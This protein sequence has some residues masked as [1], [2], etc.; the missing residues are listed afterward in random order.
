MGSI[1]RDIRYA[2][3]GLR[4]APGFTAAAVLTLALGIGATVAVFSIVYGVLLKP[5]PYAEASRL[6]VVTS[7]QHGEPS[8]MSAL[9]FVDYRSQSHSFA[10]MSAVDYNTAN[11]TRSGAAPLRLVVGQVSA[12][13]FDLLGVPAALGRTFAPDADRTGAPKTIVLG[14]GTWRDR[15]AGDPA[16]IGRT[17][18][19]DGDP[20]TVIGVAPG[21]LRYPRQAEAWVPMQ[22]KAWQMEPSGRGSH[23]FRGVGRLK[24]GVTAAQADQ[25]LRDIAARLVTQYPTTNTGVGA[26]A[27]PLQNQMVQ[28][29]R[30]AL[31]TLLAA[32][33][34]VLLVA[35]ANVANLLL[36]R[37][38]AREGEMA[39]RTALG[40][41]RW[42]LVRQL[43]SE[44][45]LLAG[46]GTGVG[47]LLARWLVD[48]VVAYGPAGLP[49]LNEVGVDGRVLLFA[50]AMAVATAI[51]FGL[52]PAL[53]GARPNVSA[54]LHASGRGSAGRRGTQRTRNVLVVV[55]TALAVV[56]LVGA[57]LFL[58]SFA[59]L[60]GVDP[61]FA[62]GNVS[63][64]TLSL[65]DIKYPNDHQVA[66][67][68]ERLLERLRAAPGVT[69]AALGFGRPLADE[70]STVVFE[71]RGEP[72]STPDTRRPTF[73]RPVSPS[74]FRVLSVPIL[75][76]RAFT[77]ADRTDGPE[78][79]IVSREF[80][81][82]YYRGKSPLG[83]FLSL[84]W[85]RDSA[86]W[87]ANTNVG[88]EIV[89]VVPDITERGPGVEPE[90][91][92]YLPFAQVPI[93]DVFVMVRSTLALPAVVAE[94]RAA[95]Q[96][97]DPDVPVFGQTTLRDALSQSIAQPR[98]YVLLL[99][100]FAGLALLLAALGIY[101]VIS[102]GVSTRI[103]EFGI[104]IALG[105]TR[106]RV[107]QLTIRQGMVLA[108]IG[109]PIGLV[110]AY[111]LTRFVVTLLFNPGAAD[112]VAFA[113]AAA[114]LL[115]AA[116]LASYLPARRAAAI[117]PAITMRA[118]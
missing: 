89:G 40:A 76:G 58:R 103:R 88:G 36:V 113:V 74:Y 87:G 104:R 82:R 30:K 107:I 94:T 8:W 66:A 61:G 19:L 78:V 73:I 81:R 54:S 20:F 75:E 101:G 62:P 1:V 60:V 27:W 85:G 48:A 69:D 84:S 47:A 45:L 34:F 116:A 68:S 4:N 98:F 71:V 42:D 114:A 26:G 112:A 109:I 10:G 25:E 18:T 79:A 83:K 111:W 100:G 21:W 38:T 106:A 16:V 17:I 67:F 57:G 99:S 95:V 56:L 86:E 53:H 63:A 41:S 37:A 110:T 15:F 24:D 28:G 32:V 105:A 12:N 44:S 65:P 117:D 9:D 14:Y 49:R 80:A 31:L 90:P 93:H 13:F 46:V 55:E 97:V 33:A 115:G 92:V 108:L 72:P 2:A 5:L 50:A 29:S 70:H 39:V 43:L 22:L 11:L 7:A 96:A 59:R 51:L 3:R 91:Y 52:A 118:E 102:Y 23:Q 64:V 77:D 35:C 6:M